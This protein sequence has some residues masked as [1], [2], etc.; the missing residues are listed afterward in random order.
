M[1]YPAPLAPPFSYLMIFD[2]KR[3]R[4]RERGGPPRRGARWVPP[5]PRPLPP[6]PLPRCEP[7]TRRR[8]CAP[9][10][11]PAGSPLVLRPAHHPT[12]P[13][14]KPS[15]A[16]CRSRVYFFC[17]P[18]A[19][20][21]RER[22]REREWG[23]GEGG[24]GGAHPPQRCAL[25][26]DRGGA[27]GRFRPAPATAPPPP[28]PPPPLH[29]VVIK[30]ERIKT[31][32]SPLFVKARAAGLAVSLV[33]GGRGVVRGGGGGGGVRAPL[34][35]RPPPDPGPRS[36]SPPPLHLRRLCPPSLPLTPLF[37]H[38]APCHPRPAASPHPTPPGPNAK[39]FMAHIPRVRRPGVPLSAPCG[40][41]TAAARPRAPCCCCSL[42]VSPSPSRAA[43]APHPLAHLS[44]HN[45]GQTRG[46]HAY[47][48]R[49]RPP[50]D[51][52][53]RGE[54]RGKSIIRMGKR[55]R[56]PVP[57]QSRHARAGPIPLP[58]PPPN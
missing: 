23:V 38:P 54:R 21:E 15:P 9:P 18:G 26:C 56:V 6:S 20:R 5:Q 3:E 39:W 49:A 29:E 37:T 1:K 13:N 25:A 42:S 31:G 58:P 32:G 34:A 35:R 14:N 51:F 33:R 12:P 44:L 41:Q 28:P 53:M 16:V 24:G 43:L 7:P 40:L 2:A 8:L 57:H 47:A 11:P 30:R 45:P 36:P 22:E 4:E 27:S 52:E 46:V 10:A 17:V 55:G 48:A 50:M 19:K